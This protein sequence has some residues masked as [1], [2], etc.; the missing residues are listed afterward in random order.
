MSLIITNPIPVLK[1]V[2]L[3][4][5]MSTLNPKKSDDFQVKEEGGYE[6]L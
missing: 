6:R 3:D 2:G 1:V 4:E 5:V